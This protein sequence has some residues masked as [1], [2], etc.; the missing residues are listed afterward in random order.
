MGPGKIIA[1]ALS[2]FGVLET[3]FIAF[4][5]TD[6]CLQFAKMYPAF[7]LFCLASLM[8]ILF[9]TLGLLAW[10]LYKLLR[11][12]VPAVEIV[13]AERKRYMP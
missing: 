4:A 10:C 7:M 2:M 9:T 5:M 12:P 8:A 3:S 13:H 6:A 1:A 11:K